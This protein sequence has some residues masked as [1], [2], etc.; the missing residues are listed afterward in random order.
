MR[1]LKPQNFK[2]VYDDKGKSL[3]FTETGPRKPRIL[4][5]PLDWGLGHASRCIPVIYELIAQ[6]CDP[7]LAAEGAQETLLKRE[8]PS[9]HF[10]TILS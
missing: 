9:L 2:I 7:W 8:F 1:G 5:A 3:P 6:N 10:W 4:V